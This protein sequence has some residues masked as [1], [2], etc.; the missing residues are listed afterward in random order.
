M[1]HFNDLS[2]LVVL[3]TILCN[4]Q[5]ILTKLIQTPDVTY[6][7]GDI[8]WTST[9]Q[10]RT[11]HSYIGIPYAEPPIGDLRWKSPVLKTKYEEPVNA[12]TW[13]YICATFWAGD[14][15]G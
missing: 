10:Q 1:C 11:F 7:N 5:I 14:N 4:A 3:I 6:D 9:F 2:L 13:S 8:H 12:E 15:P